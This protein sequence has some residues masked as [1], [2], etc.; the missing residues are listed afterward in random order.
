MSNPD[1]PGP[2]WQDDASAGRRGRPDDQSAW[3]DSGFWRA[4]DGRAA[5][6]RA[7]RS[8][9]WQSANGGDR[10]RGSRRVEGNGNGHPDERPRRAGRAVD[11]TRG[12]RANGAGRFSQTTDDLKSRLG[13]RGS[14]ASRGNSDAVGDATDQ[15][16]WGESMGRPGRAAG[17]SPGRRRAAA[18]SADLTGDRPAGGRANG[19]GGNGYR[20][21]RRAD[22]R[23]RGV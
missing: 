13:R 5:D 9:G 15:N 20:G 17:G 16:F 2:Y 21:T 14:A 1:W 23:Q 10:G 18:G 4:D 3:E 6:G 19:S 8:D 11:G 12:T 22:G 7:A